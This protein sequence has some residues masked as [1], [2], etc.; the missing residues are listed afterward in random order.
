MKMLALLT[1]ILMILIAPAMAADST[2]VP[3]TSAE[4]QKM[5]VKRQQHQQTMQDYMKKMRETKDPVEQQKLLM[6]MEEEMKTSMPAD[7]SPVPFTTVVPNANKS[8]AT[9]SAP[10]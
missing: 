2:P 6:K 5:M 9:P 8:L 4:H 7:M 1:L 10:K 3:D